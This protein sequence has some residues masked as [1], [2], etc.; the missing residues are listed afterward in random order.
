[1]YR[2]HS[3]GSNI[4]TRTRLAVTYRETVAAFGMHDVPKQTADKEWQ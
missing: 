1:M 4:N 3:V 2:S